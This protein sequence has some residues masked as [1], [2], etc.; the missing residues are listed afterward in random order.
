MAKRKKKNKVITRLREW[1]Q[2]DGIVLRWRRMVV[3]SVMMVALIAVVAYGLH[4]LEGYVLA[5][6][7]SQAPPKIEFVAAPDHLE[8]ILANAVSDFQQRPWTREDLCGDIA[9]RLSE[10]AWI[11]K[12]N[13]VHRYSDG[14]L[15]ID[16]SYRNPA[17]MVKTES[18][19]LL[20]DDEG[21]LLP[22]RYG[23]DSTLLLIEGVSTEPPSPGQ[24]WN[25]PELL[26]GIDLVHLLAN[27]TFAAQ[28]TGVSVRNF[29]GC[30]DRRAA[31]IEL[32]TD[33]AGGRIIWGSAPGE[34][35][36]ENSLEQKVQLLR[37][38][39]HRYGRV[40]ADRSVIDVSV[41]PDKVFSPT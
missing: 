24:R 23:P 6:D 1:F 17:A 9:Q 2:S 12:I 39:Y 28:I 19:M 16:C 26:A 11:K 29:R 33:R 20:V 5:Q 34:E 10:V 35:I 41:H 40:D 32:A 25:A 37:R 15:E 7:D 27:E 18:G 31:H 38:N 21:V 3:G 4:R 30:R 13:S 8:G 14:T 22:G 36:E